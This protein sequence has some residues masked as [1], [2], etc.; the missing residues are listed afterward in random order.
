MTTTET[1]TPHAAFAP[2]WAAT[3]EPVCCPL[4]DYDLRGLTDPR[5]P[6]CGHAFD[7]QELRD[8]T[9]RR[10]PWLFEHHPRRNVASFARTFLTSLLR[11][12][13]FWHGVRPVNTPV[14]RR[15]MLYALLVLPLIGAGAWAGRYAPAAREYVRDR[16][17]Y[18]DWVRHERQRIAS[19]WRVKWQIRQRHGS[20]EAYFDGMRQSRGSWWPVL[21]VR[22]R[23][24][25]S[26]WMAVSFWPF[27]VGLLAWP[28]LTLAALLLFRRSLR[29]AQVRMAH[30]ARCVVYSADAL[31]LIGLILVLSAALS[32]WARH[33]LP[34]GVTSWTVMWTRV[35]YPIH[36]LPF[37]WPVM[38]AVLC[39][40]LAVA[41]RTY[42]RFPH[43]V[44]TV[45]AS[46]VLVALVL[47]KAL[48]LWH[49]H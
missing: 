37:A 3:E 25:D 38:L 42:L 24:G 40:R 9:E 6:E 21:G 39:Y 18:A 46:Q 49:G 22:N 11:P 12:R 15:L 7:W 19:D 26:W 4:C 1:E 2:D 33:Q 48:L 29:Q 45:I 10:H 47:F 13:H 28:G 32:T 34:A 16:V 43:A 5:C 20:V 35:Q 27:V 14:P 44:A 31:V 8:R 23:G 17:E 30:V 41:Y 36:D